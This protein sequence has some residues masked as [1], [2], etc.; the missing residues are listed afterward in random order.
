MK[1]WELSP[2]VPGHVLTKYGDI[3]RRMLFDRGI[4]SEDTAEVFLHPSYESL[5]DPYLF[6]DM[7]KAVVRIFEAMEAKHT[8]VVYSDYDCDGIPAATI[9]SDFFKKIGYD[10]VRFYIPHRHDEGYGLHMD[11]VKDFVTTGAKLLLTFDLGVTAVAETAYAMANGLDVIITDHH[12][13]HGE[14]PRAFAI[15]NPHVDEQY[16]EKV[17]SG[18]G[19]A[20]KLVQGFIKKIRRVL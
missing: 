5:L 2:D 1:K 16:P 9:M 4:A 19:V 8:I 6:C 15:I 20:F 18:A 12:L 10:N 13:P 7:E 11:A 3:V 17:L 14:L